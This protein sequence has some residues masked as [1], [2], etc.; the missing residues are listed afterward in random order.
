MRIGHPSQVA[1]PVCYL[2]S[3]DASCVTNTRVVIGGGLMHHRGSLHFRMHM[4][5]SDPC[6]RA[7]PAREFP[8]LHQRAVPGCVAIDFAGAVRFHKSFS[9]VSYCVS[10]ES[11][12][13][14]AWLVR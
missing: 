14:I 2:T 4:P 6:R 3:D 5:I 8:V 9:E 13:L 10:I 12:E 7:R 11:A 1:K